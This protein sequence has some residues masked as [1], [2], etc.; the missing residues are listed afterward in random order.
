MCFSSL[1][2]RACGPRLLMVGAPPLHPG[3]NIGPRHT[4]PRT[5]TGYS[6]DLG[7]QPR[8]RGPSQGPKEPAKDPRSQPRTRGASQG[9]KEPAMD[10]RTQ[11]RSRGPSQGT[12]RLQPSGLGP[13]DPARINPEPAAMVIR[14]PKINVVPLLSFFSMNSVIF[15]KG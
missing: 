10:P 6:Q 12:C 7:T 9:P 13:R 11:P 15:K 4:Y 8:T 3:V 1:S 2:A 5:Q 14:V